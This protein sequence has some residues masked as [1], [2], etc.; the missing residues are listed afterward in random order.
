MF[1]STNFILSH[2]YSETKQKMELFILS[3]KTSKQN[4][5]KKNILFIPLHSMTFPPPKCDVK[6][7]KLSLTCIK[8]AQV[9]K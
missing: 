3:I 4:K 5:G 6:G 1:S 7:L 2:L 9:L 8:K